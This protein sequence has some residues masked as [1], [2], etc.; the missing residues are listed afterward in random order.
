[1]TGNIDLEK[2][3][4]LIEK[5]LASIPVPAD[6]KRRKLTPKVFNA[7]LMSST[8][9]LCLLLHVLRIPRFPFCFRPLYSSAVPW[10]QP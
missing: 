1:M 3:A 6:L 4:P 2:A 7:I 8:V 10:C 5:Y 9:L